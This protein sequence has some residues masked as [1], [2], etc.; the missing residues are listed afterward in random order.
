MSG[1]EKSLE[2][3]PLHEGD[4]PKEMGRKS[5]LV[6]P[7]DNPLAS[8]SNRDFLSKKS[9]YQ[10]EGDAGCRMAWEPFDAKTTDVDNKLPPLSSLRRDGWML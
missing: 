7:S 9:A 4:Y 2:L 8:G 10:V 1:E 3:N 6:K 5:L